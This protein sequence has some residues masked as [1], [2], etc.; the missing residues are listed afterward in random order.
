[1]NGRGI[2]KE[3]KNA[4][5]ETRYVITWIGPKG[6]EKW[7]KEYN[8]ENSLMNFTTEIREIFNWMRDVGAIEAKI[9]SHNGCKR[10]FYFNPYIIVDPDT[11]ENK[12]RERYWDETEEHF[13]WAQMVWQEKEI[14]KLE[15][16]KEEA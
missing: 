6:K 11:K 4:K 8:A 13:E 9:I 5:N 16:E 15:E 12:F 7:N 2:K 1:M 14:E 10:E 3:I